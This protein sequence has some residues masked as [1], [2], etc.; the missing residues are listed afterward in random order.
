M[1]EHTAIQMLFK[2]FIFPAVA[3]AF[4]V[5][6][7]SVVNF[8]NNNRALDW[9]YELLSSLLSSITTD[10]AVPWS[11]YGEAIAGMIH[12]VTSHPDF[13]FA[14]C[15]LAVAS[16]S[17][18]MAPSR[19]V[20]EAGTVIACSRAFFSIAFLLSFLCTIVETFRTRQQIFD[21][22][23]IRPSFG[24][25]YNVSCTLIDLVW[26]PLVYPMIKYVLI[27]VLS[28]AFIEMQLSSQLPPPPAVSLTD[29]LL[30]ASTIEVNEAQVHA[31][32]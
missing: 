9:C 12:A 28:N 11:V 21:S 4:A 26:Y 31:E 6:H 3:L 8:V 7:G 1:S 22:L 17:V 16:L 20:R 10:I 32:A 5:F 25:V 15:L 23:T 30:E 18:F 27:L 24:F 13:P 29:V 2:S 14:P 19:Y